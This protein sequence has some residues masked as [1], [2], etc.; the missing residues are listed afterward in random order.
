[1]P[2][3]FPVL[4][5]LLLSHVTHSVLSMAGQHLIRNLCMHNNQCLGES[6]NTEVR[7]ITIELRKI[8]LWKYPSV[9]NKCPL[10]EISQT[11]NSERFSKQEISHA[12]IMDETPLPWWGIA[13]MPFLGWEDRG[14][15]SQR[16]VRHR[17]HSNQG[18][19]SLA[20]GSLWK[21][22]GKITLMNF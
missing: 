3:T 2:L 21:L 15:D 20:H 5:W 10:E 18:P 13:R 8:S 22:T 1:M 12:S 9:E 14:V 19:S 17:G 6:I 11:H 16:S 4:C 7:D